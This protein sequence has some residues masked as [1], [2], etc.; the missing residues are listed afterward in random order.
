ML[1]TGLEK[2]VAQSDSLAVAVERGKTVLGDPCFVIVAADHEPEFWMDTKPTRKE[3]EA[4]CR[5]MGRR[6]PSPA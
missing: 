2:A 4:L 6:W 1:R 5:D 3:A